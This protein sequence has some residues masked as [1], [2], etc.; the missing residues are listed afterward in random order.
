MFLHFYCN[1]PHKD[2]V[3]DEEALRRAVGHD[4]VA[5]AYRGGYRSTGNFIRTNCLA[6]EIDNDHTDDE[7]KWVTPETILERFP[8]V[9]VGFHFSRNHM[10]EKR[11]KSPRP[12]FHVFFLIDEM[13]DPD[14]YSDLKKRVHAC[15][16]YFDTKALDAARFF[17][18]TGRPEV[19]VFDRP[20]NLTTFLNEEDFDADMGDGTYGGTLIPEGSRNA[21]MSHYAG[22]ILK[23][24]GNTEEAHNHFLEYAQNCDPP[25]DAHELDTIWRSALR[26]FGKV[27]NQEDYIP[28]EKFNQDLAL[29]PGDYSD[30]GQAIVLSRE[31][32]GK[33][34]YSPSTDYTSLLRSFSFR[35]RNFSISNV[36][37]S[38]ASAVR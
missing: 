8:D 29:K 27:S 18:G 5:V 9:T 36:F 37:L 38:S 34:R 25:L 1:Y 19:E 30:V 31:Y 21:T 32:M 2:A 33:L 15:F 16:P 22:K 14:A 20:M 17:Y 24:Y 7:T 4:Y 28:P 11:G 26:F 3:G 12:K 10:K 13:T 6:L 35:F 23:R